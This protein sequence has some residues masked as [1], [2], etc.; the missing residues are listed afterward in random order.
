MLP[1]PTHKNVTGGARQVNARGK[2]ENKGGTEY[3]AQLHDLA[4]SQMLPT[5]NAYDWNTARKPE[6]YEAYK[7]KKAEEGVNV[8]MP[9]KQLASNQMLPTQSVRRRGATL[10]GTEAGSI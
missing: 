2:R 8:Q 9:L 4:K 7:Q 5:P 3:G 10:R 6:T 1:T